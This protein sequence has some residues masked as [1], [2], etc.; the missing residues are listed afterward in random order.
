MAFGADDIDGTIDN[1]T[2]IY[3]MAGGEQRPGM[4]VEELCSLVR[5][6]GFVPVERDTHYNIIKRYDTP[7][8]AV[9]ATPQPKQTPQPVAEPQPS[10]DR[11]SKVAAASVVAAAAAT[12]ATV[13]TA[14]T[15]AT[16]AT[17]ATAAAT[18]AVKSAT[19]VVKTAGE[20]VKVATKGVAAVV[21]PVGKKHSDENSTNGMKSENKRDRE[22]VVS[23][24]EGA[25]LWGWLTSKFGGGDSRAKGTKG[26]PKRQSASNHG[27]GKGGSKWQHFWAV[28]KQAYHRYMVLFHLLFILIFLLTL[29]F[30]LYLGLK[31]GTRHNETTAVPNFIGLSLDEAVDVATGAELQ[32]VVRDTVFDEYAMPG[33]VLE[34]SPRTSDVRTVTVKAGRRIYVTINS[35]DARM[36]DMVNVS[37]K[38]LRVA[39]E[40]LNRAGLSIERLI[41]EPDDLSY[42]YVA[43]QRVG[44]REVTNENINGWGKVPYNTGVTLYIT[45]DRDNRIAEEPCV[46]GMTMRQAKRALWG[47]GLNVGDVHYDNSIEDRLDRR[48]ARV[49][50]QEL[51]SAIHNVPYRGDDV[52]L[53]LTCDSLLVDSLM[54]VVRGRLATQRQD[55][56]M[57]MSED[58]LAVDDAM[59]EMVVEEPMAESF[60]SYY[61]HAE[62]LYD[63]AVNSM[64]IYYGGE[65][66][67]F[68]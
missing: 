61:D 26:S 44:D 50:M 35:M 19:G 8:E 31:W 30:A 47:K 51:N 6:A 59:D 24:G 53:Y 10:E 21:P 29:V 40:D 39:I 37:N 64:E 42:D 60:D 67:D 52:T 32:I 54:P 7:S 16:A 22:G 43:R 36:V 18:S 5:D 11:A 68:F 23:P 57:A 41:Y 62:S 33:E 56:Q 3:S 9:V 2:K 27:N 17:T 58:S 12:T 48:D 63:K 65:E 38:T 49:Y 20:T 46:V 45:F 55:I 15:A 34:Q 66:D 13:A 28:T 25:S 4:S 14:A 1:T